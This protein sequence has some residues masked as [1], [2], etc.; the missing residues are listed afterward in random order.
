MPHIYGFL[1][2]FSFSHF[3]GYF[4]L[5]L[6]CKTN[7]IKFW[8]KVGIKQV[9]FLLSRWTSLLLCSKPVQQNWLRL[10]KNFKKP[11]A[12]RVNET[13]VTS[14]NIFI[15]NLFALESR[16][17]S[18]NDQRILFWP[19]SARGFLTCLLTLRSQVPYICGFLDCFSFSHCLAIPVAFST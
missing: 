10:F 9:K 13:K 17:E 19:S 14:R 2:C 3:F 5:L 11:C 6:E 8:T 15:D 16:K 12:Q 4:L 18:R 1:D 7:F